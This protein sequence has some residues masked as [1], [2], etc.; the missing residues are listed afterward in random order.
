MITGYW[1]YVDALA[2]ALA[3]HSPDELDVFTGD[4]ERWHQA[5]YDLQQ[6]HMEKLPEVFQDIFF[7]LASG[8]APY[9]PQVEHL[10]HVL[11]QA[12][13]MS[14]PN[15]AYLKYEMHPL[16]KSHLISM[17]KERLSEFEAP[18]RSIGESLALQLK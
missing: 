1:N 8:S 7:D 14:A 12:R 3:M 5:I 13:L 18:L 16:Q 10:L 11:A 9:S 6:A 17:N 2:Y 4:P 15:P